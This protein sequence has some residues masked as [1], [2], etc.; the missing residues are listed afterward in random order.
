MKK[1]IMLA[2]IAAVVGT[3][4][5]LLGRRGHSSKEVVEIK[6]EDMA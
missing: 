4:A 1:V 2:V 5:V 6:E 3:A